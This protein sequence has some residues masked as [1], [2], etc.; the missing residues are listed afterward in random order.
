MSQRAGYSTVRKSVALDTATLKAASVS[1]EQIAQFRESATIGNPF[2]RC[3][4]D[5]GTGFLQPPPQAHKW[6]LSS[7]FAQFDTDGDGVLDIGEFQRAFRALGL[8]KRSGAKMEVDQAMFNAFDTNGDGKVSLYE[9]EENLFPATREKIEEKLD[10]G[11][12]FDKKKWDASVARHAK[13]NMAKVFKQFDFDGDG[14]LTM[15]EF[16][17]AFRALGLKKRDGSK[18]EVDEKMFRS[19]DTNGD[20]MVSLEEF[21]KNLRPKTRAKIEDRLN[22]GWRFDHEKWATSLAR[23]AKWDMSKVFKNFDSDGDGYLSMREFQRAFRALGLKKRSGAKMEVDQSMFNSFDTNGDGVVSLKEF[24]ENLYPATRKKIED[25]LDSGWTFDAKA[26][27]DSQAR[28]AN[29]P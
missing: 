16:K 12:K 8:K 6:D 17:R 2:A 7:I 20:G 27:A 29:D 23:H 14:S 25:K 5:T 24:E 19:F 11:W 22:M 15:N 9:L 1:A 3:R 21:E 10:Q 28:H 13:W 4:L 18:M 26:W